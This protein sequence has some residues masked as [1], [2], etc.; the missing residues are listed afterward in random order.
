M[1]EYYSINI[2]NQRLLWAFT[3]KEM[4]PYHYTKRVINLIF[5]SQLCRKTTDSL[6]GSNF[7]PDFKVTKVISS[8]TYL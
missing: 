8:V 4:Y 1:P 6:I 2:L 3:V 5:H 7:K